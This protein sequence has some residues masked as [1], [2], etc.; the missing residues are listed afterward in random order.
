MRRASVLLVVPVVLLAACG[1][2][3]G[4]RAETRLLRRVAEV[5]PAVAAPDGVRPATGGSGTAR[6][7]AIPLPDDAADVVTWPQWG[8]LLLQRIGAPVCANNV[9]SVVAWAAQEGTTAGWN[10]LATTYGMPGSTRFNSHGVQNYASLEQGLEATVRT[11]EQGWSVHGYGAIVEA[12]HRCARPIESARAIRASNWCAGCAEGRY[13]T[14][15]VRAI[16]A[17]LNTG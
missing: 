10:P 1:Q 11:I 7:V 4:I 5:A 2:H 17:A 9:V 3:A 12:L 6:G 13:V 16:K 8:A 15:I 14:G